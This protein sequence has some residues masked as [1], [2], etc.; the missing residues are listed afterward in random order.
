MFFEWNSF[1]YIPIVQESKFYSSMKVPYILGPKSVPRSMECI[2]WKIGCSYRDL[3]FFRLN[4]PGFQFL[5][6]SHYTQNRQISKAWF[7]FGVMSIGTV[8][9]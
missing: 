4:L 7:H 2:T 9:A 5:M 1:L 6:P 3:Q 8:V